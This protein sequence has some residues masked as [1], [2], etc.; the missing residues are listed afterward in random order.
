MAADGRFVVSWQSHASQDGNSWGIY[1]QRYNAD[2]TAE[3]SEFQV[4]STTGNQQTS[5]E[6]AMAAN[7]DFCDH[8]AVVLTL[9]MATMTTGGSTGN[10]IPGTGLLLVA[11]YRVFDEASSSSNTCC[12]Y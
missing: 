5:P 6:V 8:V 1:A 3:G 10:D 4:N 12:G 9:T 7:G 11:R 2:G